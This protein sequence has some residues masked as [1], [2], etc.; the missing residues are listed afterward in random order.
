[1]GLTMLKLKQHNLWF[2]TL[3][4]DRLILL[5][6]PPSNFVVFWAYVPRMLLG[7]GVYQLHSQSKYIM[8]KILNQYVIFWQ[9]SEAW[10]KAL[11]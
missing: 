8:N 1:M 5:P 11:D 7:L 9:E 3:G 4:S 10:D 6:N 2:I